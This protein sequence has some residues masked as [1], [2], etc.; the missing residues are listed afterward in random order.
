[1]GVNVVTYGGKT[2]VDMTDATITPETV[3]EGY[4]G[5][6]AD[7]EPVVG[8]ASSASKTEVTVALPASGWSGR[9]QTVA[10]AGVTSEN[11]VIVT[12]LSASESEWLSCGVYASAQGDGTLTFTNSFQPTADL[13][14]TV[15]II[16]L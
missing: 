9:T 7:G 8:T 10:A 6:G 16:T 2:L 13:S 14:A 11:I 12:P 4:I 5:Y 3:L 1:M 15:T